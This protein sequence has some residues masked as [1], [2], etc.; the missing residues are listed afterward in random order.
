MREAIET[1]IANGAPSSHQ[2][3]RPESWCGIVGDKL[4]KEEPF[5]SNCITPGTEF[6]ARLSVQLEYYVRKKVIALAAGLFS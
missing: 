4:P 2:L 3:L 1:A 5:D 6:M